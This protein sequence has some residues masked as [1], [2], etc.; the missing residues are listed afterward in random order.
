MET[1]A[2][3]GVTNDGGGLI[4]SLQKKTLLMKKTCPPL[5]WRVIS[6]S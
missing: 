5:I 6:A 4:I 1:V 2:G 3:L